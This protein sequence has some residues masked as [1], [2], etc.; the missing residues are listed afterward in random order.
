MTLA[1]P[2]NQEMK[3]K[4][5]VTS[6]VTVA[7]EVRHTRTQIKCARMREKVIQR[8]EEAMSKDSESRIP[9]RMKVDQLVKKREFKNSLSLSTKRCKNKQLVE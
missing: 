5:E 1:A 2:E 9:C 7:T 3:V 8:I 6:M 4:V